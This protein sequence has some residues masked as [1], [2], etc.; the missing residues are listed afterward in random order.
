MFLKR[1]EI[2]G[3][4][5]FPNRTKIEFNKGVTAIVGP[6]GS[7]KSNILDAILWVLGEQSAKALR[8]FKMEDIIFNGTEN[9]KPLSF[10]EVSIVID[11]TAKYFNIEYDEIIVT[12]RAFRSGDNEY[13]INNK[14]CRLKDINTLFM[15][16]G[17]GKTGYS[18]ISQGKVEEIVSSRGNDR[19]NF[20]DEAVGIVKFRSKKTE[21]LNN[22]AK[23]RENLEKIDM[24]VNELG[25]RVEPLRVQSEKAKKFLELE[26]ELRKI[27]ITRYVVNCS[28]LYEN[29]KL[30]DKDILNAK[31]ELEKYNISLGKE[32][33]F[34]SENEKKNEKALLE[35]ENFL[36]RISEIDLKKSDLTNSVNLHKERI[37]HISEEQKR[38]QNEIKSDLNEITEFEKEITNLEQEEQ[39]FIITKASLEKEQ[40][41][42]EAEFVEMKKS[43]DKIAEEINTFSSSVS[44][45]ALEKNEL[46]KELEIAKNNLNYTKNTIEQVNIM[47]VENEK[48]YKEIDIKLQVKEK[49]RKE[50]EEEYKKL[51]RLILEKNQDYINKTSDLENTRNKRKKIAFDF[52]TIQKKY[53]IL[54]NTIKE[55]DGVGY[56]VKFILDRNILGVIDILGN[57]INVDKRYIPAIDTAMGGYIQNIVVDNENIA[58]NCVNLL[59]E[60]KKGRATFLPISSMKGKFVNND[61][62]K[63]DGFIGIAIDLV[64]F[65]DKYKNIMSSIL[66]NIIVM[67]DMDSAIKFTK[68]YSSKYRVVTLDGQ[69]FNTSGSISGG[70][71]NFKNNSILFRK[72]ELKKLK[73]D[74]EIIFSKLNPMEVKERS[75]SDELSKL[76]NELDEYTSNQNNITLEIKEDYMICANFKGTLEELSK[77]KD[78]ILT[79]TSDHKKTL[80]KYEESVVTL[81]NSLNDISEKYKEVNLKLDK[82]NVDNNKNIGFKEN[83]IEK[84]GDFRVNLL[85]VNK[86]IEARSQKILD[87]KSQ[88]NKL[89]ESVSN[90]ENLFASNDENI[91][92]KNTEIS[93]ILSDFDSLILEK[94]QVRS[95]Y[96]DISE[97]IGNLTF[98]VK[99]LQGNIDGIK[100]DIYNVQRTIDKLTQEREIQDNKISDFHNYIWDKYDVSYIEAKEQPFIE[101]LA[102]DK[103]LGRIER[104]LSS[105]I[106][107][108]GHIN[109]ESI[110]EYITVKERFDF[111]NGQRCDIIDSENNILELINSLTMEMEELFKT[112]F[113]IIKENFD[114]VFKEM[115]GGGEAKLVL[116]DSENILDSNIEIKAQPPGKRLEHMSLLSGGEKALTAISLLFAILRMKPSPFCILD[117]V[118]SALDE[119]NVIK[120]GEYLQKF[121]KYTQFIAITHR[122]GT[123]EAANSM[124]GVTMQEKGV[125]TLVSVEFS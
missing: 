57:L 47:A 46:S 101:E 119:A 17:V 96:E 35:K 116:S 107:E 7:G 97:E 5:S 18:I 104:M 70:Y 105:K 81:T 79:N 80:D 45:F 88:I 65:D 76:S 33:Y 93:G 10:A 16:T 55:N 92:L 30:F 1:L 113:E 19:K 11:N 49:K 27:E 40:A 43:F 77:Q 23:E 13:L 110:E 74:K 37:R 89:L 20:F 94:E 60:N 108:L 121:T 114:Y 95:D 14:Q 21:A 48:K 64:R 2:Q 59:K 91:S 38:L 3:F 34:F 122:N 90:K 56:S 53:D 100:K 71:K 68:K 98:L 125:S 62:S 67:E 58:K 36:K 31:E 63:E 111:L 72:E 112:Q 12:R 78:E 123:M 103:D 75:L 32:E 39:G 44:K 8:G 52:D 51:D 26:D 124:Y 120:Y 41:D 109:V 86:N 42:F 54:E 66:G 24:L 115:F 117:E 15:D 99:K 29:L 28:S 9:R 82:L 85:E 25:E 118:E 4:K 102:K 61:F 106:K 50:N 87:V 83:Y 22:L 73:E 6:N 84:I 69:N